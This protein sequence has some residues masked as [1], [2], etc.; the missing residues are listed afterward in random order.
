MALKSGSYL[1]KL[2]FMQALRLTNLNRDCRFPLTFFK[3]E[4]DCSCIRGAKHD[5][6]SN[7]HSLQ[8]VVCDEKRISSSDNQ[9][10]WELEFFYL[11][12]LVFDRELCLL[13]RK[14]FQMFIQ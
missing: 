1:I 12:P 11:C 8:C 6:Y 9:P 7:T 2:S 3:R 5:Q 10:V 13:S 14:Y 4:N